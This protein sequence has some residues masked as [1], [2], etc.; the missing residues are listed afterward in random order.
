MSKK[1]R[2]VSI[3]VGLMLSTSGI[4]RP[5]DNAKSITREDAEKIVLE[6]LQSQGHDSYSK[7]FDLEA[8]P[9]VSSSGYFE[10]DAY[11]DSSERLVAL[12][13]FAVDLQSAE[14]WELVTC[15]RISPSSKR[16][17]QRTQ[18]QKIGKGRLKESRRPPS[19]K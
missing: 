4:A 16:P 2:I 13:S 3:L 17:L 12:G 10:A 9:E 15:S 14:L 18:L 5:R 8:R 11:F 6:Y 19:C 7:K 1:V